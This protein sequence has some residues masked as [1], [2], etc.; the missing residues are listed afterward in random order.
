MPRSD[1]IQSSVALLRG[2]DVREHPPL[3]L[4]AAKT[5][6]GALATRR[7][8]EGRVTSVVSSTGRDY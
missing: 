7:R 4:S 8:R 1:E 6:G 2:A 5:A 3:E